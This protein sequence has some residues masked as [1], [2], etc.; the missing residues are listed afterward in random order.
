MKRRLLLTVVSVGVVMT[1][2]I[3]PVN[4]QTPEGLTGKYGGAM[5]KNT[6]TLIRM[7]EKMKQGIDFYALGSQPSWSLDIDFD[8]FMRFKSL[9][10]LP[11]LNTPPGREAK[12]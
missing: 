9:T 1:M 7:Q 2:A 5:Q 10:A 4:S 8:K 3:L 11:E 12:A 6:D